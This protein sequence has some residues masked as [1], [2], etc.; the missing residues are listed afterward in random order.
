MEELEEIEY[1]KKKD[2]RTP[3]EKYCDG[4]NRIGVRRFDGHIN[5]FTYMTENGEIIHET[6]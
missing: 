3:R 4:P 5:A 1:P 6:P 2:N